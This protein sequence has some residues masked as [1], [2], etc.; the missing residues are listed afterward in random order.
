[1][2]P[3]SP[4]AL[5]EDNI[6]IYVCTRFDAWYDITRTGSYKYFATRIYMSYMN[7]SAFNATECCK[8]FILDRKSVV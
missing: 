7:F 1:M 8:Y 2:H 4:R 6:Y 5:L 3:A